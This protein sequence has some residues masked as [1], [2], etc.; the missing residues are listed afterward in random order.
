M[1]DLKTIF[2]PDW[3]PYGIEANRHTLETLIRNMREQDLLEKPI[4]MKDLFPQSVVDEF[5]I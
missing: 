5:K 3:W 4:E 2:G 1:D